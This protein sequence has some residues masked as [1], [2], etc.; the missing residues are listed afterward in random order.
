MADGGHQVRA[1]EW[2]PALHRRLL[3]RSFSLR[4]SAT[5]SKS[6]GVK[7]E[8]LLIVS[9]NTTPTES[10]VEITLLLMMGAARNHRNVWQML[11]PERWQS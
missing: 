8:S 10:P 2:S 5:E 7:S 9:G 6:A 4:P 11:S 1:D 3:S